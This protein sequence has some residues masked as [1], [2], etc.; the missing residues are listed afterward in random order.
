MLVTP[1][2]RAPITTFMIEPVSDY[3]FRSAIFQNQKSAPTLNPFSNSTLSLEE[4]PI[5]LRLYRLRGLGS[6]SVLATSRSGTP[7]TPIPGRTRFTLCVPLNRFP[8]LP[9]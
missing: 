7:T 1:S 8:V 9:D 5:Q 2:W 4:T 3:G 6:G